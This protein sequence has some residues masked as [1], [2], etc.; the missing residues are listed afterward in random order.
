MRN[1]DI[2]GLQEPRSNNEVTETSLEVESK[3]ECKKISE[4]DE[5]TKEQKKNLCSKHKQM[6][7]EH[8]G[9]DENDQVL[10]IDEY[11]VNY[12]DE[13]SKEQKRSERV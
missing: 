6:I 11:P 8:N 5:L 7:N 2:K 13:N 4:V 9:F 3:E 1:L 10:D 12:F